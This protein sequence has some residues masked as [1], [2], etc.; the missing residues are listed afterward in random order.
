MTANKDN[1]SP[2]FP[3]YGIPETGMTYRRYLA[4]QMAPSCFHPDIVREMVQTIKKEENCTTAEAIVLTR[5]EL[6]RTVW[7]L[8][9]T[10]IAEEH[11]D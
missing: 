7:Y 1:T 10:I 3:V 2:A 9:D 8:A 5:K 4:G 6:A 11:S